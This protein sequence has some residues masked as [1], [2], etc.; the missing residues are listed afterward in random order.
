MEKELNPVEFVG[1]VG[2]VL[3]VACGDRMPP[4]KKPSAM[5]KLS[6]V[7]QT[8]K[9]AFVAGAPAVKL[10]VEDDAWY[11]KPTEETA[12]TPPPPQQPFSSYV[13]K[14][15]TPDAVSW[16]SDMTDPAFLAGKGE[17]R[18]GAWGADSEKPE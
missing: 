14:E 8:A 3:K 7:V 1:F 2:D 5:A 11:Q 9:Q 17:I 4:E 16:P 18:K 10:N 15:E 13:R 12:A 6:E